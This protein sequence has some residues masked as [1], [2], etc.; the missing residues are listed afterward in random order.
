MG[1]IS[2][3]LIFPTCNDIFALNRRQVELYGGDWV[4]EDNLINPGSLE[5]VLEAIQYPLFGTDLYPTLVEKAARL[6]WAIIDS[7][8]FW[9]ACKRTGMSALE[10]FLILNGYQF[11]A[12]EVEVIDVAGKIARRVEEGYS[13]EEFVNW[14]R[15]KISLPLVN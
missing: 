5:W 1:G 10:T 8:I 2:C 14:L 4:G 7:H 3:S 6:A 11:I 9:S 15:T 13:F 12:V